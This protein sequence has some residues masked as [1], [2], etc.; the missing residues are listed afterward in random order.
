MAELEYKEIA[1]TGTRTCAFRSNS[2]RGNSMNTR[3]SLSNRRA[4]E[5]V[6]SCDLIYHEK[7]FVVGYALNAK[8]MRKRTRSDVECAMSSGAE[9][10]SVSVL[11][12][13]LNYYMCSYFLLHTI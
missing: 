3:T 7:V 11:C 5:R 2:L 1:S 8:K 10:K 9:D 12:I 13:F 4:N 6:S